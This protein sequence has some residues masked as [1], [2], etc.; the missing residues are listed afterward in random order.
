MLSEVPTITADRRAGPRYTGAMSSMRFRA[1]RTGSLSSNEGDCCLRPCH[2]I[3]IRP[4][5]RML[6]ASRSG[7]GCQVLTAS[8]AMPC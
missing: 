6:I 3:S 5:T 1:N 4:L 8:A 7:L 2:T